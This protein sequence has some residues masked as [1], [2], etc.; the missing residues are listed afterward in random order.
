[1]SSITCE[2]RLQSLVNTRLLQEGPNAILVDELIFDSTDLE[3]T[4]YDEDSVE[5]IESLCAQV[6]ENLT[7]F[8]YVKTLRLRFHYE[9]HRQLQPLVGTSTELR[10][11]YT[12][13]QALANNPRP[14]TL[15][16]LEITG[17]NT[18]PGDVCHKVF[19]SKAFQ[20]FLLPTRALSLSF[21]SD[22]NFQ[23]SDDEEPA[24]FW[25]DIFP[26]FLFYTPIISS[27]E[28]KCNDA[29]NTS[30]INWQ[31]Y[32]IPY[33][34]N[35]AFHGFMYVDTLERF[36]LQHKANLAYLTIDDCSILINNFE[37]IYKPRYWA[38]V[39]RLLEQET[40]LAELNVSPSIARSAGIYA[41]DGS[42]TYIEK[43]GYYI[44]FGDG[45]QLHS[46]RIQG[47]ED[48]MPALASFKRRVQLN[49]R[50]Y[51]PGMLSRL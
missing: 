9:F 12:V 44:D 7:C 39:F 18:A 48:D 11:Q 13:L 15:V 21:D 5:Q 40:E 19:V 45:I 36:V 17:I 47:E 50:G 31:G 43:M 35:L 30:F 10:V 2:P 28:L 6:F 16:N 42:V 46:G 22:P 34:N 32:N 41:G 29:A 20:E 23:S 8:P 27:L 51:Q 1:M 3:D 33:L 49:P 24:S 38:N 4:G 25:S 14:D 37:Q 26:T